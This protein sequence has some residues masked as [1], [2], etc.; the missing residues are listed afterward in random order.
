MNYKKAII[1]FVFML[2]LNTSTQAHD[3]QQIREQTFKVIRDFAITEATF[4]AIFASVVFIA[5][6][7]KTYFDMKNDLNKSEISQETFSWN[8]FFY[9]VK[10]IFSNFKWYHVLYFNL[11]FLSSLYVPSYSYFHFMPIVLP[12]P[13]AY[14][15]HI[16]PRYIQPPPPLFFPILPPMIVFH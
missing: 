8:K 5:S 7:V 12:P 9:N 15:T 11:S 3:T 14:S 4:V 2:R 16:P 10:T 13:S 1:I 6:G